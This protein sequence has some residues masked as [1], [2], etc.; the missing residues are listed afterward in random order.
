MKRFYQKPYFLTKAIIVG[1]IAVTSILV[2]VITLFQPSNVSPTELSFARGLSYPATAEAIGAKCGDT[3]VLDLDTNNSPVLP[4]NI[5]KK[6]YTYAMGNT[7]IPIYGY[8]DKRTLTTKQITFYT[9]TDFRALT[10]QHKISRERI[11]R[12]MF[13]KNTLV[14]W[15]DPS[16]TK[17]N[18]ISNLESYAKQNEGKVL[19][20]PWLWKDS[21]PAGRAFAFARWGISQSCGELEMKLVNSFAIFSNKH[22]VP[23]PEKLY[24]IPEGTPSEKLPN[25]ISL[26]E[27]WGTK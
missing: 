27:N 11:L 5:L 21:M 10:K 23:R 17:A 25:P 18:D 14:I 1:I 15:Y 6:H 7:L 20:V 9:P 12:T 16:Q 4:D 2:I 8:L 3:Y 13:E 22:K 26:P 19:I 24:Q